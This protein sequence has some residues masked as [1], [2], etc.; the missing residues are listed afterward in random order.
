MNHYRKY[1]KVQSKVN[2]FTSNGQLSIAGKTRSFVLLNQG[3]Q[4]VTVGINGN[5]FLLSAGDSITFGGYDDSL[6]YDD[7]T[8]IF[9][10]AGVKRLLII[11]DILLS[12]PSYI[13]K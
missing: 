7:L 9:S 6:R 3:D 11:Q 2:G 5:D 4:D 13:G 10:G 8:F 1:G 12:E